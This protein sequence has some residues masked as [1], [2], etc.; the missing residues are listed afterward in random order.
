[1]VKCGFK[2]H[3]NLSC[4]P[5]KINYIRTRTNTHILYMRLIIMAKQNPMIDAQKDNEKGI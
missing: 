2:M 4:C 5:L 3:S 1:M